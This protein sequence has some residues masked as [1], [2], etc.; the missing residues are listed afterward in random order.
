VKLLKE[1]SESA[2]KVVFMYPNNS[3]QINDCEES[4]GRFYGLSEMWTLMLDSSPLTPELSSM[5]LDDL[6]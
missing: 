5:V 6:M 3:G 2:N 1:F 4:V